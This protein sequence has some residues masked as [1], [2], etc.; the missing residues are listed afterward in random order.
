M[1]TILKLSLFICV[2]MPLVVSQAAPTVTKIAAGYGHSLFIKSDGSLW[3]MGDNFVGQ[4]GDGTTDNDN[5]YTNLPEE[6]VASN[7]TTIAAGTWDSF[8]RKSNGSLWA[9]GNESGQVGGSNTNYFP[10]VPTQILPSQ[11]TA[12]AA[13]DGFNLYGQY[14]SPTGPGS[15]WAMGGNGNGQLGDGTTVSTNVPQEIFSTVIGVAVSAIACGDAHSLYIRSG[16][17]LWGMGFNGDG[18]LGDGTTTDRHSPVEIEFS[19]VVAVAAGGDHSLFIKS[20]GSLWAMGANG[21]GQLGDGTT[22][23][24]NHFTNLPEEI[25]FSNVVA[26]TAGALHSLFLKSDG[27]LWAMGNNEYGQL[28][29]GTTDDQAV[30][31]EIVASNVVAVAAGTEGFHSLFIKSDGSLWGMGYNIAGQLGDGTTNDSHIPIQIIP[32]AL[33]NG[34]FESGDFRGWTTSGNFVFT[35][36]T[37]KPATYVHSGT[38]GAE[39]G[40]VGALGY[41]SQNFLTTAGANYLLSFWLDNPDGATP[42]EFLVSWNGATLLDETN[43]PATGWTHFQF[44]VPANG[45]SAVLQ[46]GFR[47]DNSYFGL[48]DISIVPDEQ[49]VITGIQ[50]AGTNLVLSAANGQ[51]GGTYFTLMSTNLALPLNQWTPVTTNLLSAYGD[52]TIT[53]TNEVNSNAPQQFYILQLQN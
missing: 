6:I 21:D 31:Q 20:D 46:F 44:Q 39:L 23:G 5:Y 42:N 37:P 48:D 22:D 47:N 50:L 49:P 33:K 18:Q 40:P 14:H 24:G 28:G 13:G 38:Y 1:K 43:L 32:Y 19:N 51:A 3:A 26:V 52:F 4:L 30:P 17:S 41:L 11:V 27:S 2:L 12:I 53:A 9:M 7:V 34:G 10:S 29:D 36:V 16:G 25:V 8:F 45:S 15:L 35:Y